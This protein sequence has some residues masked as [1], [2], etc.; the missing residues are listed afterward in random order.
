MAQFV[1]LKNAM[2]DD[3]QDKR[4]LVPLTAYVVRSLCLRYYASVRPLLHPDLCGPDGATTSPCGGPHSLKRMLEWRPPTT[5]PQERY[6]ILYVS[7][8]CCVVTGSFSRDAVPY[9]QSTFVWQLVRGGFYLRYLHRSSDEQPKSDPI[10]FLY[11]RADGHRCRLHCVGRVFSSR[12]TLRDYEQALPPY[13][14]R[15]HRSFI[16]NCYQIARV[17][18]TAVYLSNGAEIPLAPKRRA[19]LLSCLDSV[20]EPL[21]P[22]SR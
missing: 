5:P 21:L 9:A 7:A 13:F 4:Q 22:L 10:S 11:L 8:H 16:V 12:R 15:V 3:R 20:S 18:A 2:A 1:G 17:T 14:C 6:R 19:G